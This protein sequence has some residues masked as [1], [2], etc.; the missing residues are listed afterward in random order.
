MG[1]PSEAVR[2]MVNG[3]QVTFNIPVYGAFDGGP[4]GLRYSSVL[5]ITRPP[6]VSVVQ[7]L[8]VIFHLQAAKLRE[9]N[10]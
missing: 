9:K 2:V 3:L 10:D 8:A 5:Y 4:F 6:T 7:C 1:Q